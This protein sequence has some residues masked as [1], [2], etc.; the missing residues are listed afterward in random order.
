MLKMRFVLYA[1]LFANISLFAQFGRLD[2]AVQPEMAWKDRSVVLSF[3]NEFRV[4]SPNRKDP[5]RISLPP[6]T[7]DNR[8]AQGYFWVLQDD[9]TE[10]RLRISRSE[11]GHTWEYVAS[12]F[13]TNEYSGQ[14]SSKLFYIHPLSENIFLLVARAGAKWFRVDNG[15]YPVVVAKVNHKKELKVDCAVDFGFRE[16]LGWEKDG[17]FVFNTHY[18]WFMSGIL[19]RPFL[20][21][22]DKVF[23]AFRR[24]GTFIEVKNNGKVGK[25]FKI[26][27]EL[28]EKRASDTNNY[29]WAVLCAQPTE[30]DE[31]L[32]LSRTQDGVLEGRKYFPRAYSRSIMTDKEKESD[33]NHGDAAA[34]AAYPLMDWWQLS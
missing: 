25:T 32:V 20:T 24:V 5:E 13:V 22:G 7:V 27:P 4:F 21:V 12:W 29:D 3:R 33:V 18:V 2:P 31:I 23:L 30:Y 8:Y 34:L 15:L 26:I 19:N 6:S 14:S 16:K 28:D 10:R 9:P 11:D 1:L 17:E